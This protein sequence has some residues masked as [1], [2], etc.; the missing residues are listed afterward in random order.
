MVILRRTQKLSGLL[1]RAASIPDRSATALGDW[2][3]NRIVIH[4]QPL[5]ILVSSVSLLSIL[6]PA[7][8]VRNLPNQL[9]AIVKERLQRCGIPANV[10]QEETRAMEPVVVGPTVDRRVLG[11]M[12]DYAKMLPFHLDPFKTDEIAYWRAEEMLA[13]NPCFAGGPSDQVILPDKKTRL[14]LE[15]RWRL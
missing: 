7:R 4:R 13:E 14:A 3:V 11:I 1:P 2:Y 12:V 10:V 8:D 5:L 15:L 9:A 6:I